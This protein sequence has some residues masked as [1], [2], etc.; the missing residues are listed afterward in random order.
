MNFKKPIKELKKLPYPLCFKKNKTTQFFEE[1]ESF[2]AWMTK[3]PQDVVQMVL[4]LTVGILRWRVSKL[5]FAR[6]EHKLFLVWRSEE[7]DGCQLSYNLMGYMKGAGLLTSALRRTLR[8]REQVRGSCQTGDAP[9]W[10][11]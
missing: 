7:P 9:C 11:N 10:P 6:A 1:R 4:L 5:I 2:Y 8:E 3:N